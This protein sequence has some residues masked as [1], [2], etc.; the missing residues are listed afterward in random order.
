MDQWALWLYDFWRELELISCDWKADLITGVI[1]KGTKSLGPLDQ[2]FDINL[3]INED[4]QSI[5]ETLATQDDID[6]FATRI[7]N[8]E[9][10]DEVEWEFQGIPLNNTFYIVNGD[11]FL[12]R[13]TF[14]LFQHIP[15]PFR[16][17]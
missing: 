5:T 3:L 12:I 4:N 16:L 10:D 14:I 17:D 1:E 11:K 6:F 15:Y 2:L 13:K 7:V 9:S 8:D